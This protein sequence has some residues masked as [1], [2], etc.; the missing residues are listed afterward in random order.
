VRPPEKLLLVAFLA[1]RIAAVL[2]EFG[3]VFLDLRVDLVG[4]RIDGGLHV[5]RLHIG[6]D[7][8]IADAVD[9]GF[10]L[11]QKFLHA[12]HDGDVIQMIEVPADALELGRDVIAQCVGDGDLMA[13]DDDLHNYL[14]N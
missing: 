1:H 10:G 2:D 11:L 7:G 14:L 6:V 12:Q 5:G 3:F 9:G 4:E 13:R 8:F